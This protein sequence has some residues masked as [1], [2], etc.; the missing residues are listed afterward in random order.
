MDVSSDMRLVRFLKDDQFKTYVEPTIFYAEWNSDMIIAVRHPETEGGWFD[1]SIDEYY[2]L[3]VS[4]DN[5]YGPF[6]EDEFSEVRDDFGIANKL[7]FEIE[8]GELK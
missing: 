7:E 3:T 6:S 2:L 1:R 8:F 5:L 4:D